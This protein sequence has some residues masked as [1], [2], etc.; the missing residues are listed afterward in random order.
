MKQIIRTISA[1]AMA[2]ILSIYVAKADLLDNTYVELGGGINFA[3]NITSDETQFKSYNNILLHSSAGF[4]INDYLSNEVSFDYS[5]LDFAI[6]EDDVKIGRATS[7]VPTLL[8]NIYLNLPLVQDTNLRLGV[9]YG[10]SKIDFYYHNYNDETVTKAV[11]H[12]FTSTYS[13][14]ASLVNKLTNNIDLL[15]IYKYMNLGQDNTSII[16]LRTNNFIIGF[17]YNFNNT[18]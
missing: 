7:K 16:K 8:Y 5:E 17:R 14:N 13:L 12:H 18:N 6:H 3:N 4:Y 11:R 9:G 10:V 2:A 15:F 1:I